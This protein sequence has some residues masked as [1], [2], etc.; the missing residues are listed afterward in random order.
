VSGV[1]GFNGD[2]H[3]DILFRHD[4]GATSIWLMNG[5]SIAG[6]WGTVTGNPGNDWTIAGVGDF[7]ADHKSDILWQD[8][9]GAMK[10][11][12]IDGLHTAATGSVGALGSDWTVS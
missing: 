4:G 12:L 8:M 3:D 11:E 6:G 9:N 10:V 1:G 2:A 7:N 5:E